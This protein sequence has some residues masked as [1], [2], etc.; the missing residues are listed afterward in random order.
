[1]NTA[2]QRKF[3]SWYT[4]WLLPAI[5]GI[6]L[7][8]FGF[9][10]YLVPRI[11]Y[12]RY[13]TLRKVLGFLVPMAVGG[14]LSALSIMRLYKHRCA[15]YAPD[16]A[17]QLNLNQKRWLLW[18]PPLGL[19]VMATGLLLSTYWTVFLLHE[20]L[21]WAPFCCIYILGCIYFG[22]FF[23]HH[24]NEYPSPDHWLRFKCYSVLV[25]ILLGAAFAFSR[26]I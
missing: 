24:W 1:M 11:G 20:D 18:A 2:S 25:G 8:I 17:D 9:V 6:I 22:F 15:I 5:A 23:I 12:L 3:L 13:L 10:V 16:Q 21:L 19:S 4:L 14:S 7:V 26:I